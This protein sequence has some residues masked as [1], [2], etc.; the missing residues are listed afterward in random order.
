[1][2]AA[3][4]EKP[5]HAPQ[6]QN[7]VVRDIEDGDIDHVVALWHEAGLYRPWNDPLK[8]IAFAR[9]DPHATVLVAL[10]REAIVATAMVGEDGHRGWVYYVATDPGRRGEGLGRL[11]MQAAEDWL[12]RRGVWKMHL[13]VREGNSAVI[14]F[15][16]HLGFRDGKVVCMQKVI[17]RTGSEE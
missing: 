13:L 9:R 5:P 12:L 11:I 1:M 3:F 2:T 14:D 6:P 7:V 4:E 16:E 10:D 15:Y 8:D 17:A